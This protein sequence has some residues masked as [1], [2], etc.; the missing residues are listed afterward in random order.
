M[1]FNSIEFLFY[2]LPLFMAV[3]LIFP[4]RWRNACLSIGSL[5]FLALGSQG[6]YWRL[7]LLVG[8]TLVTYLIGLAVD[9]GRRKWLVAV[10]LF[11]MVSLLAFFKCF[12]GGK[13]LPPGLSFYL[14]QMAAYLIDVNRKHLNA[15]RGLVRYSTQIMMF[16]KLLSGPLVTP[17]ELQRQ[18]WGR[19]YL[20]Q[21]FHYGIQKLILGLALKVLLADRLSP[22]W[23]QATILGYE[24]ISAPFAWIA[25]VS[26]AM[27]MYFD[28]FGYSLMAIGLGEMLGFELPENF[29]DPY[30]SRS[31][32]EF[33]RR[34][35]ITLGAWFREYIYIPLGGSH[36]GIGKTVRNLCIVW[37]LTGLWHGIGASYLLWASVIGLL[38]VNE[39]LWLGNVLKKTKILSHV[40][41]VFAILLSWLPF[42]IPSTQ[43]L[44][45]YFLRLFGTGGVALNPRDY[46]VI[47]RSHGILLCVGLLFLTPLPGRLYRRFKDCRWL[48]VLLF[49]LFWVIVYF[50][51]T[52][53]RDPF[54][55]F[56]F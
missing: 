29:R 7:G 23:N 13:L 27:R 5:V 18:T 6:S 28:F 4:Q 17:S 12:Q 51:A 45:V 20:N 21:D 19:G 26:Y 10:S 43:K 32:S 34:W 49:L 41:T 33:Y 30:A 53:E 1:Q 42:A 50:L 11:L 24:S 38:I 16:P 2:F 44:Q 37:L 56:Q 15:E 14:F 8:L 31:V 40:Y 48:N 46:L 39:K 47:L 3:Y 55:Y 54:L 36:Q 52:A 25:L 22:V 9:G 35:H